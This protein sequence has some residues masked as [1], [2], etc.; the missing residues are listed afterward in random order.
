MKDSEEGSLVSHVSISG[1][2]SEA[3]GAATW[4]ELHGSKSS[5]D[6]II[7]LR[8]CTYSGRPFGE[9]SFVSAIEERFQ[10]KWRRSAKESQREIAKTA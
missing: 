6:Q 2:G 10:R 9:E 7:A 4:A 8:K 5:V 3:G 1:F